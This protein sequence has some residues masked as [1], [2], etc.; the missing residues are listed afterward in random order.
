MYFVAGIH[1]QY[2]MRVIK[3]ERR[4][5]SH[6]INSAMWRNMCPIVPSRNEVWHNALELL[7]LRQRSKM[8]FTIPGW[9]PVSVR[10][11]DTSQ[12]RWNK[13]TCHSL[14]AFINPCKA[15][16][17]HPQTSP[18]STHSQSL[19]HPSQGIKYHSVVAINIHPGSS[20]SSQFW[21][22]LLFVIRPRALCGVSPC[23][24]AEKTLW[25]G[26]CGLGSLCWKEQ[27]SVGASNLPLSDLTHALHCDRV[28]RQDAASTCA[29]PG[30]LPESLELR[31]RRNNQRGLWRPQNILW[32][33][34]A[35]VW[36]LLVKRLRSTS[37][38]WSQ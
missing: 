32:K 20:I 11:W 27:L 5:R 23:I 33:K 13:R 19:L 10:R 15:L 26:I 35:A 36:S 12:C 22:S 29:R 8:V 4:K 34:I 3:I 38:A 24:L 6:S 28:C 16:S 2:G 21:F 37:T 18:T 31:S 1:W 14:Y 30:L 17:V 9:Y 7:W 25:E